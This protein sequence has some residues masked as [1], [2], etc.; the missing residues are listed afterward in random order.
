MVQNGKFK[1][2]EQGQLLQQGHHVVVC[3]IDAN[4]RFEYG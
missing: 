1:D 3:Y 4:S 2:P